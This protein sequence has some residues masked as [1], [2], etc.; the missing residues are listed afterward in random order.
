MTTKE[1]FSAEIAN[2]DK[3]ILYKEGIFYKAYEKSAYAFVLRLNP[4]ATKK[5]YVKVICSDLVSIG[6]PMTSLDK[7][8]DQVEILER[9][10]ERIVIKTDDINT[11]EFEAWK[12]ALPIHEPQPKEVVSQVEEPKAEVSNHSR[13]VEMIR[14]FAVENKTPIECMLFIGELKRVLN[15]SI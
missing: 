4:Y 7:F 1:I 14:S 12:E 15:G 3:I 13:I 9:T 5:K 2:I 10:D 6:F 11:T 8:K